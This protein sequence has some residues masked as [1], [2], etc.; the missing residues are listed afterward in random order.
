MRIEVRV[1]A[2]EGPLDLLLHLISK[3]EIDIY[4]IPIVKVTDQYLQ[5]MAELPE[6]DL[7]TTTEFL[8]MAATLIEIKSKML[9]P[10]Q[11]GDMDE[12][13]FSEDDPRQELVKRLIE[14]KKY[15]D[16]AAAL[17]EKESALD[18]VVFKEQEELDQ[19]TRKVSLDE[20]NRDLEVDLLTEAVKRL[21]VKIERFDEQRKL[22]FKGIKRDLFTVEEKIDY[23]RSKFET[24][25]IVQFSSL[26]GQT[27]TKE[28]V[29]VTFLAI[30]EL[31]K[32]KVISIK[33]ESLFDEISIHQR[34]DY[35]EE[36]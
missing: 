7:D 23:I 22:F 20:L 10:D 16:A 4:D 5:S 12:F 25:E 14:Y 19:Y 15:K 9:L 33:Q 6:M 32:M 1:E 35:N 21:I 26:F 36:A 34:T 18:E 8:V 31:L 3:E 30:L 11:K 2:F 17:R 29:V 13:E 24:G 27:K 28:E